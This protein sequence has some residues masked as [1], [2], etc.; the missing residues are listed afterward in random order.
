MSSLLFQVF[1]L[2]RENTQLENV[3]D[4]IFENTKG[5]YVEEKFRRIHKKTCTE[6]SFFFDKVKVCISA[7]SL[8]SERP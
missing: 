2:S 3:R 7:A 5:I 8:K 1:K 4:I 6:V